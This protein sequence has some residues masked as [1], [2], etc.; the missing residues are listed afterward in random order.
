MWGEGNRRD[1]GPR[2]ALRCTE[3]D[4]VFFRKT[5]GRALDLN[6]DKFCERLRDDCG[7]FIVGHA[8]SGTSILLDALNTSSD[9]YLLGEANLHVEGGREG[10]VRWYNDMH[11]K[12]GNPEF[13]GTY[14]PALVGNDSTGFEALKAL[15]NRFRYV[16]EKLAF[17]SPSLGY[18]IEGF[19]HSCARLF[20]RSAFVCIVRNPLDVIESC[21]R[22]FENDTREERVVN[23]YVDSYLRVIYLQLRVLFQF[24]RTYILIHERISSTSFD[25]LG[26]ELSIRLDAAHGLYDG[27]IAARRR[28]RAAALEGSAALRR[29]IDLYNEISGEI[30]DETLRPKRLLPFRDVMYRLSRE[31]ASAPTVAVPA[32]T[33]P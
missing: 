15:S 4:L 22:M 33:V 30:S 32:G 26:Q 8:R 31:V 23:T 19:F 11:R 27:Q 14:C 13:K 24:D 28:S 29:L 17:R 6:V 21:L 9:V 25:R 3:V 10:F 1:H 2:V 5:A 20:L 12:F 18:D 7:L 16:G